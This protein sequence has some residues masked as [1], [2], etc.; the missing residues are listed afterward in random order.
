MN[1]SPVFTIG[2]SHTRSEVALR[3]HCFAQAL[4]RAD[5]ATRVRGNLS[6]HVV[7]QLVPESCRLVESARC[8]DLRVHRELTGPHED[9]DSDTVV[10]E[11]PSEPEALIGLRK[12]KPPQRANPGAP[13]GSDEPSQVH[14]GRKRGL[15]DRDGWFRRREGTGAQ[16]FEGA[17]RGAVTAA[18]SL[19]QFV[20]S[21]AMEC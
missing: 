1:V 9:F 7:E 21:E 3:A 13:K 4:S 12:P 8:V 15:E 6:R 20:L 19:D 18:R 17:A 11:G 2:A 5:S 10:L 14:V 16:N